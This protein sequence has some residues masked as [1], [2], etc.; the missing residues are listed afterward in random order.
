V[1]RAALF[2]LL[3][4]PVAA[5][6]VTRQQDLETT[7]AQHAFGKY[8]IVIRHQERTKPLT[9][10]QI[11]AGIKPIWCSSFLEIWEKGQPINHL[12]FDDIWPLGTRAGIYLPAKQESKGHFILM[13]YGDYDGRTIIIADDGKLFNLGGGTYRIFRNR[14]L[15]TPRALP[16]V[17][18]NGEFSVFDLQKNTVLMNPRWHDLARDGRERSTPSTWNIVKFYT[19]GPEI[20]AGIVLS[21]IGGRVLEDP[22]FFYRLDLE[23]GKLVNAIYESR[24]HQE[25]VIDY[26]NMDLKHL[27]VYE[28]SSKFAPQ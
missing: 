10:E 5:Q 19:N 9:Q 20:F 27:A 22:S 26:S 4:F 18:E 12:D 7:E 2:L 15:V 25:F 24:T 3:V 28:H 13:K 21:D 17:D 14:Y 23:S 8:I 6:Q 1:R 16:D 11:D